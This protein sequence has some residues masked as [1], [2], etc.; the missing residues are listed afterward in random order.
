MLFRPRTRIPQRRTEI[1]QR[2][3]ELA[4]EAARLEQEHR[5]RAARMAEI[6]R[7]LAELRDRT[8]RPWIAGRR[9]RHRRARIPAPAPVGRPVPPAVRVRGRALRYAAL[10]V[11]LRAGKALTLP[12]IHRALHASGFAIDGHH[13]VKQL[14]DALGYEH[15]CGRA[16]RVERGVY[17]AA[18][19]SPYR[20]RKA[21]Q[22]G[23]HLDHELTGLRGVQAHGDARVA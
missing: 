10:G 4:A 19:L 20:R 5:D 18:Q 3:Q 22:A 14:A 17:Q 11:L 23:D 12:E 13:P 15:D 8:D 9:P 2:Q 21:L 16:H 1:T 7:E 6:R